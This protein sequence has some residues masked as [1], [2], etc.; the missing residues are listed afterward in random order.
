MVDYKIVLSS[1]GDEFIIS[2]DGEGHLVEDGMAGF[3]C[4]GFDVLVSS[5]ASGVGG[6]AVRRRFAEREMTLVFELDGMGEAA[7]LIR[8]K[9]VS[10]LN[11]SCEV[12]IDV[13][14]YGKARRISALP[15]GEAEFRRESSLG[16]VIEAEVSFISPSVYFEEAEGIKVQF[17]DAA[18]ILTFPLNLMADAGTV[19]GMYRTT[20]RARVSNSGDG[21]CGIVARIRASGGE[22]VNPGIRLGEKYVRCPLTLGDGHEL[23]IDTRER[24][25]SVLVDGERYF[26]FDRGSEFFSLP[27]G[28]S[29]VAV[30]CDCGGEY[31]DAQLEFS[32]IYYGI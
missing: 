5:Y 26:S 24:R 14:M 20:D 1:G 13:M 2:P 25:K 7:D 4:T 17:R 12:M 6:Y 29:E 15:A 30:L 23:V 3:D 32:P 21:E 16:G 10:M 9:L 8:R 31:I 11:P 18:P 19:G 22:V 28:V 27:A